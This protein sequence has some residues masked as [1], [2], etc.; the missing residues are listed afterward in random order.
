MSRG[1]IGSLNASQVNQINK[2][3][4]RK[5]AENEVL[6]ADF[7]GKEV[8]FSAKKPKINSKTKQENPVKGSD[9][10]V[11][12]LG[13]KDRKVSPAMAQKLIAA[14]KASEGIHASMPDIRLLNE[15]LA[16]SSSSQ[17]SDWGSTTSVD[18]AKGNSISGSNS[19]LNTLHSG[20]GSTSSLDSAKGSSIS[21]STES[22]DSLDSDSDSAAPPPLPP[23]PL[24]HSS[25]STQQLYQGVTNRLDSGT[26]RSIPRATQSRVSPDIGEHLSPGEK[27]ALSLSKKVTQFINNGSYIDAHKQLA[28]ESLQA[29]K[30]NHIKNGRW[31]R[32]GYKDQVIGNVPLPEKT[33]L[34]IDGSYI[35]ANKITLNNTNYIAIQAPQ[36]GYGGDIWQ[37]AIDSNSSIICDLTGDND[38]LG[39]RKGGPIAEYY[40]TKE[41]LEINFENG[42]KVAFN[43]QMQGDGYTKT[44]YRVTDTSGKTRMVR[45][46]NYTEWPDHGVPSEN[47]GKNSCPVKTKVKTRYSSI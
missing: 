26:G 17:P 23:R 44:R 24:K 47:K 1:G 27:T 11:E 7:K 41:K 4:S 29:I 35:P 22:L 12:T 33:A 3:A 18:S 30:G 45:R 39:F 46:Y 20:W 2:L 28:H 6:V 40:P 21:G 32:F 19:S 15:H 5:G 16:D 42:I 14:W 13:L 10:A 37:S 36:T 25:S 8:R 9:L 38:K 31:K 43:G 34:K